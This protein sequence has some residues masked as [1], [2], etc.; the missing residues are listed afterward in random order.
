MRP[1]GRANSSTCVCVVDTLK[2]AVTVPARTMQA[3]PNG[4][5]L[6][7]IKSD[8][9]VEQRIVTVAETENDSSV[10]LERSRAGEQV[11]VDGQYR[12]DQGT[13]VSILPPQSQPAPADQRLTGASTTRAQPAC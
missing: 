2:N 3:G 5:Y 6:F 1:C 8:D 10:D 4:S 7:V 11:V 9:S 12:L 13:K